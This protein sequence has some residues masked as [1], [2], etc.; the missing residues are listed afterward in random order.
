VEYIASDFI[1]AYCCLATVN[2]TRNPIVAYVSWGVL[3]SNTSHCSLLK[4]V[5]PEQPNGP[6]SFRWSPGFPCTSPFDATR[7]MT[8]QYTKNLL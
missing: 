4:I 1:G 8:L 7:G 2:N 5:R 3:P 6:S